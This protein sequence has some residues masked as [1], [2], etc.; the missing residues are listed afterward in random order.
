MRVLKS[1][2]YKLFPAIY[3]NTLGYQKNKYYSDFCDEMRKV[4][5][6]AGGKVRRY[7]EIRRL[8]MDR[9]TVIGK[10]ECNKLAAEMEREFREVKESVKSL[11]Q[12]KAQK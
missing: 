11:E 9:L 10:V 12:E 6:N 5:Q 4:F 8:K 7:E 3:R 2:E 1:V